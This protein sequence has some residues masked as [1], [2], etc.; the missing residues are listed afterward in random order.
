MGILTS[1]LSPYV[2]IYKRLR[3]KKENTLSTKKKVRFTK[4]EENTLST[5]KKNTTLTKKKRKKK[6]RDQD[7][8]KK[9]RS[10]PIKASFKDRS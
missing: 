4:K 3:K 8:E 2:G 9:T 10:R 7:K 5:N 1:A 6:D